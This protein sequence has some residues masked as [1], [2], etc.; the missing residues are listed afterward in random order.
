MVTSEAAQTREALV[1]TRGRDARRIQDGWRRVGLAVQSAGADFRRAVSEIAAE[2]SQRPA[3][4]PMP[5][6][7]AGR[8]GI[9]D[10]GAD[11]RGGVA[12]RNGEVTQRAKVGRKT[13]HGVSGVARQRRGR[14]GGPW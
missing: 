10:V 11:A 1:V 6:R 5:A 12:V 9:G 7:A 4:S 3:H 13:Q 2:K 8:R 14:N